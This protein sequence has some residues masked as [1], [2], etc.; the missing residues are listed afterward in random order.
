ME[1][2][3]AFLDRYLAKQMGTDEVFAAQLISHSRD[4][5]LCMQLSSSQTPPLL[6]P[7]GPIVCDGNRYYLKKNWDYETELLQQVRRLASLSPPPLHDTK[8]FEDELQQAPLQPEQ[9]EAIRAALSKSFTLICGGPGTGKTYTAGHLVKILTSSFKI[10]TP[11]YI[12]LAAPTGKA[13]AHLAKTIGARSHLTA[14]TLHRLLKKKGRIDADL[15]IID[16][17]S[18]IDLV[19]WVKLL[20]AIGST[21]RLVVLGDPDQLPPIEAGSLFAEMAPLFGTSLS[22]CMRTDDAHL[23]QLAEAIRN[24]DPERLLPFVKPSIQHLYESISPW[25]GP[26]KPDPTTLLTKYRRLGVLCA[27]RQG[28]QGVNT[29]QKQILEQLKRNLP[30]NHWW[31][32]P[33]LVTA[34]DPRQELY[35]GTLGVMIGQG[36]V[37]HL[38]G[39]AY[40]PDTSGNLKPISSPPPMEPAFCLSIHKSQGSEYEEVIAIFPEG[41]QRLG[42]EALYTAVTRAKKKLEIVGE[43]KIL[44]EMLTAYSRR[45]SGFT[46]RF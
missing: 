20:K 24:G 14:S 7:N 31:A 16:E 5:H 30:F 1:F 17:G 21:T 36:D 19:L 23:K 39:T 11:F 34:N 4:G 25:T 38:R 3:K 8:K 43:E 46:E 18:M 45:I 44:R 40:F 35:N 26:E 27:L 9:K 12:A 29:L 32:I 42:R 2:E 13:A 10:P 15:V 37:S 33:V 22:R 28:P 6:L 41:S